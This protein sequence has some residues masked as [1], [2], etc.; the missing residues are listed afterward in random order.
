MALEIGIVGPEL[1]TVRKLAPGDAEMVLGRDAD[2]DIC[3]PDPQRN[4]SRRHL[5][6]WN[7]AGELHFR[8]LSV[9]NG[10]EMPFGEAPPGAQG[11]LPPGQS[12]KVGDYRVEILQADAQADPWA[13]FDRDGDGARPLPGPP[14]PPVA[15]EDDPFGDWG[16]E[17]T[18]GPGLGGAAAMGP[19]G[20]GAPDVTA[21]FQGMGL[22]PAKLGPLSPGE[23]ETV[24]RAV[25]M[26]VTGLLD[27]YASRNDVTQDLRAEDR[28]MVAVK[29]NNP[30][31]TD[32]PEQT[33]LQYLFGGRAASVGFIG[34]ERALRSLLGDLLAHDAAVGAAARAAVEGTLRE[35]SPATLRTR[36]L[37]GGSKLFEGARAW[38][39]YGK[40][41]AEHSQ[42]MTAWAQRLLDK[43][44]TEAYL[45]ESARSRRET[46]S[47]SR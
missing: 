44:F 18:F 6:V 41:Y 10:V 36:L 22:D 3:L 21:F 33:K 5:A 17:S 38:D 42:D 35:F 39:A 4:V 13:V 31:K 32:W 15:S 26:V 20:P 7:E 37:G 23:L 30:L 40:Y 11:V 47:G 25:R 9:V 46:G 34:P 8:V 19:S 2:C 27:L 43:H 45:R 24:G 16:F 14:A 29:D 12:L 28:T 1:D